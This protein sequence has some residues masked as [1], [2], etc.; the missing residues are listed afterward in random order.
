MSRK[1][2]YLTIGGAVMALV[3]FMAAVFI[4]G[5]VTTVIDA[6]EPTLLVV[7]PGETLSQVAR[8]LARE[9]RVNHPL[10]LTALGVLRGDSGRIQAGEYVVRGRVSPN[11]LLNYFVSGKARF[12]SL[13]IPE[14]YSI[15]EI[16]AALEEKGLGN[17]GEFRRL[18]R[19]AT[20]IAS[21][22]LPVKNQPPTLEGF[23]YPDTYFFHR[24]TSEARLIETMVGEFRKRT[25]KLL[26]I[27]GRRFALSPYE[28]LILASIIEKETGVGM[29]RH[30]IA[31]VFHNRL[32]TRMRLDS[33]PTVIYGLKN[34][35]GNLKRVHLRA[36]TPYNTYKIKGLPPTPIA[37]PGLAAIQAAIAPAK[38]DYLFFVA[39]GDGTHFFSKDLKTHSKAVLKYQ[40]RP[41]RRKRKS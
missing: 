35:D 31:A 29:E 1:F 40:I 30:L 39:K 22:D 10:L 19:D 34:F 17:A 16:A 11:D 12:I 7:Q 4:F 21:L 38:V 8:R 41:H 27:G 37:N 9:G 20:F 18:T 5:E 14:G 33:D 6:R 25:T 15:D 13:T 24:G 36:K 23:V 26:K 28:L 32:S 2:S 3:V